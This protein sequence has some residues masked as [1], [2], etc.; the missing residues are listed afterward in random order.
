MLGKKLSEVS[1]L[2]TV[3]I[4]YLIEQKVKVNQSC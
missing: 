1:V 4:F 3:S 2:F